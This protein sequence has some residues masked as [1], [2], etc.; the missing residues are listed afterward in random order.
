MKIIVVGCEH[1]KIITT[2]YLDQIG[3]DYE[4]SITPDYEYD[5]TSL[6]PRWNQYNVNPVGA[7]RCFRGHQLALSKSY[8]DY[9]LILEDDAVPLVDNWFEIINRV[10]NFVIEKNRVLVLHLRNAQP[11]S[12]IDHDG[13]NLVSSVMIQNGVQW[14]LGSLAYLV[15]PSMRE[16][17]RLSVYDGMPMDLFLLNRCPYYWLRYPNLFQHDRKH[18]SVVENAI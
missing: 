10:K 18:G 15:G 11:T 4:V 14:G 17:I 12:G 2:E 9:T 16:R 6:D 8:D 3:L 7:L 13:M 5:S 1:K